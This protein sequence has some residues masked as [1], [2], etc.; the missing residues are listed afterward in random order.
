MAPILAHYAARMVI[1]PLLAF[2][3]SRIAGLIRSARTVVIETAERD[4][5]KRAASGLEESVVAPRVP[6][7][8]PGQDRPGAVAHGR[9]RRC[10]RTASAT[11]S[12]SGAGSAG[13]I[14]PS[15]EGSMTSASNHA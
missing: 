2:E 7:S 3:P 11:R 1:W 5:L 8:P 10:Y 4:F 6:E 15:P 14:G 9:P 12:A 13:S